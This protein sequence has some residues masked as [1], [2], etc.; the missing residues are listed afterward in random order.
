LLIGDAGK[1]AWQKS[2]NFVPQNALRAAL[3]IGFSAKL[4]SRV[5]A[6]R[7]AGF[8][9]ASRCWS[10]VYKNL[11]GFCWLLVSWGTSGETRS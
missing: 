10:A 5:Y 8:A 7:S 6:L 9:Q 4:P 3:L 2:L 1:R 11:Q